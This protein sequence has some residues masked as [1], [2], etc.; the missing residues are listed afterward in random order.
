MYFYPQGVRDIRKA[1]KP[2]D[3][4]NFH[5]ISRL[6]TRNSARLFDKLET[7]KQFLLAGFYAK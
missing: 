7:G 6:W 5:F 1:A 4:M 3:T 2:P